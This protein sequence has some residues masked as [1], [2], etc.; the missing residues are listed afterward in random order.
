MDDNII[1]CR[2]QEVARREILAAIADGARTIDGIKRR[3]RSGMGLC[4]GKTCERLV[5]Q[6]LAGETGRHPAEIMPQTSRMPVRPVKISV[7]GGLDDER[8]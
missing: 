6:I 7:L 1:I 3:V 5:A 8:E 4:Q 2:C